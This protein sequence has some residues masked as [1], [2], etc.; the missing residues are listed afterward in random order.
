MKS[1]IFKI[2]IMSVTLILIILYLFS[3]NYLS[4]PISFNNYKF[5]SKHYYLFLLGIGG[6]FLILL[7]N[8][9]IIRKRL[10]IFQN[11][12]ITRNWFN[13][14]LFCGILGPI[15]IL[16]HS[17]FHAR[18]LVSISFWSMVI[19]VVSGVVG[20][21]FYLQVLGSKH[22][23][24]DRLEESKI[25]LI[26]LLEKEGIIEPD[27][28]KLFTFNDVKNNH[29]KNIFSNILKSIYLDFKLNVETNRESEN[30]SNE[31]SIQLSSYKR[32]LKKLNFW[33]VCQNF[34]GY[35]HSF[36]LP[37]AIFMYIAAIIHIISSLLFA[38]NK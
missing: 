16:F 29:K 24:I 28:D 30:F 2:I 26:N 19:C 36:H 15:I 13:F 5:P 14:H 3:N 20:R 12:G 11:I 35:W 4:V 18:G 32:L 34:L 31:V 7:S 10:G 8:L 38:I 25:V 23:V 9:Y 37:F 27:F 33:D 6:F 21:Y 1:K 22:K 17:N